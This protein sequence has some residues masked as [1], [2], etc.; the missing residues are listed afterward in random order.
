MNPG[1]PACK[2]TFLCPHA[3]ATSWRNCS[4]LPEMAALS[5]PG[6]G[7]GEGGDPGTD[8]WVCR[9]LWVTVNEVAFPAAGIDAN[10]GS[11]LSCLGSA[12]PRQAEHVTGLAPGEL[13]LCLSPRSAGCLGANRHEFF[14]WHP[15]QQQQVLAVV[16]SI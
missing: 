1:L 12:E 8:L 6:V 2:P 4:R 7:A 10:D 16:L 5:S 9:G 14:P 3:C 15:G 13:R 11:S